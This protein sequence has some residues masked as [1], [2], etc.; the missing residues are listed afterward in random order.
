MIIDGRAL[1]RAVL[2]R[3][4]AR[5]ELLDHAPKVAALVA[6]PTPATES[7]MSIK[8]NRAAEAGC[9]LEVVRLGSDSTTDELIA[10]IKALTADAIIVQLP[11][12]DSIDTH[13]VCD[14]IPVEKDTDV[15]SASARARNVDLRNPHV[16]PPVVGAVQEIFETYRV[17][18]KGKK[19][20]VVGAGYL[21]GA[22]VAAWL[23]EQGAEVVIVTRESG[24]LRSALA[25]AD[26][27]VSG[28]GSPR[29]I[30]HGMIKDGVVLIDAG[31][32]ESGG[33]IVGDADPACA[34]KCS[35]FTPVPGGIGPVA[36]A[37]LFE[38]AVTLVELA[39]HSR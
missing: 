17:N 16:V 9:A 19:T 25:A 8:S 7:Y 5:V 22:P 10:V 6:N 30:T 35:L 11:L 15:L 20:V 21:V 14:A 23:K 12:P 3:T 13:A 29:L 2:E 34:A 37:K 1:A 36:V 39:M 38:N 27:I 24:G 33:A 31:T 28:A 4:K 26:L 32:S 18:A